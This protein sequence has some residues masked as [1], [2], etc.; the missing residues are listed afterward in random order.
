MA[1]LRLKSRRV[2]KK[3]DLGCRLLRFVARGL[4]STH[5]PLLAHVIPMRRCNLSC[6]YCNEYDSHSDPVP[7]QEMYRRLDRLAEFGTSIITISGGEPLMHPQLEEIVAHVRRRGMIAGLISNGYLMT[8]NRIE[9]FNR[10]GL[11]HLQISIDN[12]HPDDVSMKSLKVLDQ[13]LSTLAEYAAFHVNINSVLGSGVKNPEDALTVARR[14][15]SLGFTCTVGVIHNDGGCLKPLNEKE[16]QIYY[17]IKK[18]ARHSYA[19]VDYFQKNLVE[20]KPRNWRCRAGGRYLY[21]CENGLV[22][23]CSQQR[24]YPAIPL[25]KYTPEDIRREYN[26]QK[27]CTSFCTVSC[28]NQVSTMDFWRDPQTLRVTPRP[29]TIAVASSLGGLISVQHS[30]ATGPRTGPATLH[31]PLWTRAKSQS[32]KPR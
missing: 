8:R 10:A 24:G 4:L 17:E 13:K 21:I 27:S 5:H 11:D 32:V 25:E 9:A 19:R 18:L 30:G 23:Y 26:T 12:V 14:A 20:G 7:V 29:R 31:S 28:V 2:L 22:H 16:R 1:T 3:I 15:V 6:A